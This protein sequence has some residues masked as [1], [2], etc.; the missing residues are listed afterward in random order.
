MD[1]IDLLNLAK[2]STRFEA[3]AKIVLNKRYINEYFFVDV[4]TFN[5]QTYQEF[6]RFFGN[7]INAIEVRDDGNGEQ[8][9]IA[10]LLHG[11]FV[12]NNLKKIKLDLL[13]VNENSNELLLA[14]YARWTITHLTIRN[15]F[16]NRDN[17][18]LLSN[19]QNLKA[20]ELVDNPCISFETLK[21]VIL[22]NSELDSL[23]IGE[24]TK[25]MHGTWIL[26]RYPF[27]D[28]M[29]VLIYAAGYFQQQ[30]K[31]FS[32]VPMSFSSIPQATW[33]MLQTDYILNTFKHLES[34]ALA[35]SPV[36]RFT[37]VNKLLHCLG[38]RCENIKHLKLYQI[39]GG[40]EKFYEA[41]ET[42]QRIES[43]HLTFFHLLNYDRLESM[44]ERLPSL[45]HL[46]IGLYDD[47]INWSFVV[48]IISKCPLLETLT[49]SAEHI[50]CQFDIFTN[51]RFFDHFND[52]T[53]MRN[54]EITVKCEDEIVGTITK[55]QIIWRN[56]LVH[57]VGYDPTKNVSLISLLDLANQ[58]NTE[59]YN[60]QQQKNSP[61]NMILSYLDLI[62]LHSFSKTNQKCSE[63]V[64]SFVTQHAQKQGT[65][66]ITNEFLAPHD[67]DNRR[68]DG[69][70][71]KLNVI[72]LKVNVYHN[73]I[74]ELQHMICH[75]RNLNK[76]YV[77]VHTTA[78]T[79][80]CDLIEPQVRH[81]IFDGRRT[82]SLSGFQELS[83]QCPELETLEFKQ[84]DPFDM[85]TDL[86]E[87]RLEFH[88]LKKFTFGYH[89]ELQLQQLQNVFKRANTKLNF[90]F[91][92]N[93]TSDYL[94]N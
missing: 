24:R 50:N 19:F 62:S 37:D 83:F 7:E 92:E 57:W 54:C 76:L 23:Y 72:N 30:L 10:W 17:G 41:I 64:E 11:L 71:A 67:T 77:H 38:S 9:W 78:T 29:D 94:L 93:K 20:L 22:N 12:A 60:D 13:H 5:S 43:L 79:E 86:I 51:V 58:S 80:L 34:L 39:C 46:H 82:Q 40:D 14:H 15:V 4:S 70:F 21:E 3:I 8:H 65:F 90:Q 1:D 73:H 42:F 56:K 6:Q 59:S 35:H 75:F 27:N 2:N 16:C 26:E 63:L 66:M 44:V 36:Y 61:F 68:L 49:I 31:E 88:N 87:N 74:D 81:Y 69:A 91:N 89:D 45:R 47:N 52:S 53:Q 85:D 33:T 84:P 48:M 32:Y 18:F 55:D 25:N 28:L